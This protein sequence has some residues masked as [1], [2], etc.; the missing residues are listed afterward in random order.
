VHDTEVIGESIDEPTSGC[1]VEICGRT[2]NKS[3]Q[4]V[5]V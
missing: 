1:G 2:S 3:N 4:H 5:I